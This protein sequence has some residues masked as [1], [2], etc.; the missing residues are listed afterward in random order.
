MAFDLVCGRAA[1]ERRQT[2]VGDASIRRL[3]K[4]RQVFQNVAVDGLEASG[5][6]VMQLFFFVIDAPDRKARL[7][8]LPLLS[9]QTS[10][11]S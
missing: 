4:R 10:I 6:K 3:V 8:C 5:S 9:F 2:T 7:L 1:I 11:M